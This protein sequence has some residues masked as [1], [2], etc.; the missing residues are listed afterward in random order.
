MI[1]DTSVLIEIDRGTDE[2]K[3][4][5]L[6]SRA[7]H[8]ISSVTVSE[9]FAGVHMRDSKEEEKA[10]KIISQAREVPLEREIAKKAGELIALKNEKDLGINL[11]DIY[12]ASTAIIHGEKVLTKDISDFNEIEEIEV[13]S[14]KDFGT[15]NEI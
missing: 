6:D 12:I 15:R 5:E 1:L 7:P 13:K 2:E 11:N 14:W 9:F 3:V 8:K 4:R 10:E